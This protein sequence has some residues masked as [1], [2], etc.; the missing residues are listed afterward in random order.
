MGPQLSGPP[1]V[2]RARPT[3]ISKSRYGNVSAVS[4]PD[5]T[6][7]AR[8]LLLCHLNDVHLFIGSISP[9]TLLSRQLQCGNRNWPL[10]PASS[11]FGS[12]R[13]REPCRVLAATRPATIRLFP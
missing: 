4:G 3:G 11:L 2:I 10:G 9:R 13:H 6:R 8:R 1:P 5:E 12:I 7:P